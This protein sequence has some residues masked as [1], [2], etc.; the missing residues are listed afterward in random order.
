MI[1]FNAGFQPERDAYLLGFGLSEA[2][3]VR[4]LEQND[5]I[6]IHANTLGLPRSG[7][8]FFIFAGENQKDIELRA[9]QFLN[10]ITQTPQEITCLHVDNQFY[11]IPIVGNLG[12]TLFLIG[13]D[14]QSYTTLREGKILSFRARM[15]EG[16]GTN[17]EVMLFWGIDEHAIEVALREEGLISPQTTIVRPEENQHA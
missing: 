8:H 4:L 14:S 15:V 13:L 11:V 6:V 5:P 1:K 9:K 12:K 2:N 17:V 3:L 7:S 16:K 10:V